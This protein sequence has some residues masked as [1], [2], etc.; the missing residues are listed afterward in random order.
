[1]KQKSCFSLNDSHSFNRAATA[2]LQHWQRDAV[3]RWNF[4]TKSS[5]TSLDLPRLHM[6]FIFVLWASVALRVT[7][8]SAIK[9]D[10]E[11]RSDAP[12]CALLL[13]GTCPPLVPGHRQQDLFHAVYSVLPQAG[14]HAHSMCGPRFTVPLKEKI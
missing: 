8:L 7:Q 3:L 11:F 2:H 10:T 13:N 12:G 9:S 5:G 4:S 1:V 14:G 6:A